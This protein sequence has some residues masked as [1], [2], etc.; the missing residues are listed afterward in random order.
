ME[1]PVKMRFGRLLLTVVLFS[2]AAPRWQKNDI[3]PAPPTPKQPVVDEY[4]GVKVTEDYRW[5][6]DDKNP[7]VIAWTSAQDAY[8]RGILDPLPLHAAIYQFMRKLGGSRSPSYYSLNARGGVLFAMNSQPGKQQDMLVTLRSANDPG[9][10]HVVLDPSQV[11]PTNSTAIQFFEPSLDGSKVA[12]C[13]AAGGELVGPIS[14][15]DVASGHALPDLLT[16][17]GGLTGASVA[18]NTDSSGFYYTHYPQEGERPPEDLNFYEQVYFHKLGTP[19]SQDTYVMGKD[20]PRIVE[21][22]LS[23]SKDGRY[24]LAAVGNGDGNRYEH[25]LREP[26]GE[27]KQ[28][29]QFSDEVKMMAFGD[30]GALYMLS[31]QNA[32]REKILRVPVATPE[33]KNAKTIVPQSAAVLQDFLFTLAGL[34]PAFVATANFL[35][36][37]ELAGGPTEIHIFDHEGR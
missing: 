16:H 2:S 4:H 7:Q 17:V 23:E 33:V 29:S 30:D 18:W 6:E 26:S 11:D 34:Q 14:V 35:Y 10:K 21:I 28:L 37:I 3:P 36:V 19:Q 9:S 25:F 31:H 20:F 8:A 32:P 22:R 15:Y 27:W 5:L 1:I 12:V 13:L 24:V